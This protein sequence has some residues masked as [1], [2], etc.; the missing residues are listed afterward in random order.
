MSKPTSRWIAVRDALRGAPP[1]KIKVVCPVGRGHF[2]ANVQVVVPQQDILGGDNPAILIAPL[3][4][5]GRSLGDGQTLGDVYDEQNPQFRI[6]AD[7]GYHVSMCC[8]RGKCSYRGTF[9]YD[10]LA[11]DLATSVLAGHAEHR[12]IN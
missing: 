3:A 5:D 6:Y 4:T 10:G 7:N 12:L 8:K 9:D 1:A 2:I 11:V